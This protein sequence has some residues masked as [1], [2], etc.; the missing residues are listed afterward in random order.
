[1]TVQP[2]EPAVIRIEI[3]LR[4]ILFA[5]A[6]IFALFIFRS[7][8][9]NALTPA[10]QAKRDLQRID[11]QMKVK[12]DKLSEKKIGDLTVSDLDELRE[13]RAWAGG[14]N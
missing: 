3:I 13:C 8:T 6:V 10:E 4:R 12:C 14:R 11:E 9:S 5:I 7:C 1:M 2:T